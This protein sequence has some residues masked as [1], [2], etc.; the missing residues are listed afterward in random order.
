MA[1]FTK[2]RKALNKKEI[3]TEMNNPTEWIST[4]SAV[5]NY[6]LTGRFDV[7]IPN[8]RSMLYWGPSG[9]GKTFLTS[10]AAKDAQAKGYKII[11]IDSEDSISEDYM[12]KIGIDL[13]P[14]MFLPIS[15]ATIEEATAAIAEI[16]SILDPTDKFI[17]IIDSLAGMLSEKEDDEFS[18]GVSK[19]DM[20]QMSKKLKLFTKN[21][22]K[23]I[24]RY[25]AFCIMVSHAYQNQDIYSGEGPWICTGGKGF[26]FFPSMAVRLVQA[27]LKDT[28]GRSGVRIKFQVNKTR[29]TAPRQEGELRVPY[30]AGV[31]FIDGM[32][33]VLVEEGAV[34]KSG[35][36]YNYENESGEVVKFQQ[37]K[38]HDHYEAIMRKYSKESL[39]ES[40]EHFGDDVAE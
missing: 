34:E 6:R 1:D 7:G 28:E 18:K 9:G 22:N 38:F 30:N 32:L 8:K 2:L 35:A 20:G 26:Q 25:D 4:G 19:G 13:S 40:D 5:L 24:S 11:Y 37:S 39:E 29:F 12:T 33:D 15:V 10:N 17:L 31:D 21:I 3:M 16:F 23:R 27:N 14:D 36:W